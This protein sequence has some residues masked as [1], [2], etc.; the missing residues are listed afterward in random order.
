M[1]TQTK[2]KFSGKYFIGIIKYGL[3]T[4]LGLSLV[5]LFRLL[6]NKPVL[7]VMSYWE[8]IFL[9]FFIYLG[10]WLYRKELK[11]KKLSF[12]ESYFVA[13]G[14]GIIGSIIYGM[15]IFIYASY[16]DSSF[17]MRCFD[18]QRAVSTNASLTDQ[19]IESMVK[20]SSIAVSSMFFVSLISIFAGLIIALLL[21]NKKKTLQDKEIKNID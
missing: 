9:L 13:F 16:I 1:E 6:I 4:G 8:M 12:A 20:P 11:E 10:V 7:S 14:S 5:V 18:I 17:Q 15:F 2:S 21:M 19:Q 3:L